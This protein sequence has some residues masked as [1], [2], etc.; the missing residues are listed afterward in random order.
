MADYFTQGVVRTPIHISKDTIE[1]LSQGRDGLD[2]SEWGFP[3]GFPEV[4][5]DRFNIFSGEIEEWKE[6]GEDACYI[7]FEEGWEDSDLQILAWL[8][9]RSGKERCYLEWA[10]TCSKMRADGFG[11]GAAVIFA[12]GTIKS[13]STYEWLIAEEGK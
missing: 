5:P 4:D 12:D 7:Y 8:L 3:E 11:G 6:H 2:G 10:N 1:I 9:R 13:F